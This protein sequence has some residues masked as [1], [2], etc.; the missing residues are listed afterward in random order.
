[1][2]CTYRGGIRIL[3]WIIHYRI[4]GL[5]GVLWRLRLL[6]TDCCLLCHGRVLF[7]W[8]GRS[9]RSYTWDNAGHD[10]RMRLGRGDGREHG[11]KSLARILPH[12][13]CR[14]IITISPVHSKMSCGYSHTAEAS[15][16]LACRNGLKSSLRCTGAPFF[17]GIRVPKNGFGGTALAVPVLGPLVVGGDAFVG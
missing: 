1:M 8:R 14:T 5:L 2:S 3:R 10:W 11:G 15:E 7:V 17:G 4:L 12:R 13:R 9:R 16:T 6:L